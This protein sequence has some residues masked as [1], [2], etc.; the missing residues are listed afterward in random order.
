METWET[1]LLF[2]HNDHRRRV[3]LAVDPKLAAEARRHADWMARL[4]RLSHDE[5]RVTFAQRMRRSGYRYSAIGE[6]V[7][8]GPTPALAFANWLLSPGHRRNLLDERFRHVGFGRAVASNSSVYWC[9]IL[10]APA[11]WIRSLMWPVLPAPAAA[12]PD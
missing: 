3:M 9:A 11:G 4:S 10:G 7:G 1:E 8:P 2:L 12:L 6:N 5:G